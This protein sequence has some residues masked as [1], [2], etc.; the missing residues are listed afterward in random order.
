MPTVSCQRIKAKSYSRNSQLTYIA[1]TLLSAVA[2]HSPFDYTNYALWYSPDIELLSVSFISIDIL[3]WLFVIATSAADYLPE[4]TRACK[5]GRSPKELRPVFFDI[6][7][8]LCTFSTDCLICFI[9]FIFLATECFA[10]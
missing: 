6:S 3:Y 10:T 2:D 4:S 9:F 7:H 5:D 8:H 1:P